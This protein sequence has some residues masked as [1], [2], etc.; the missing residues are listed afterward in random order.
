MRVLSRIVG[1]FPNAFRGSQLRH[2]GG[3][4]RSPVAVE[5][6]EARGLL[7]SLPGVSL[8][9][10]NLAITSLR[11]SGNVAQVSIDSVTK[12]IQV[13]VNGQTEEFGANLVFNVTYKGSQGG[14]DTFV[15]STKLVSLEYGYGGN[16]NFTGGTSFNYVYFFGNSNSF[17][18]PAGSVSDVFTNHGQN[19]TTH[20]SG[21]IYVY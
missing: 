6:L 13:S 12:N 20:G 5:T 7:T 21:T 8:T 14:G 11:P 4:R 1:S 9:F 2:S 10:G 16:N 17:T 15:D 19:D 3:H 18:G